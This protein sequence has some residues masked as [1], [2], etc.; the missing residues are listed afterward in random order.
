MRPE[1]NIK[2][3]KLISSNESSEVVVVN[4]ILLVLM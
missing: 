4:G 3:R 2:E 1:S